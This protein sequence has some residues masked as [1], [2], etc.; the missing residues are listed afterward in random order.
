MANA[1]ISTIPT[2]VIIA[3]E[4]SVKEREYWLEKLSGSP[5]KATFPYDYNKKEPDQ[6]K[7]GESRSGT[8]ETVKFKLN[9][10]VFSKLI[11]IINES[12][13]RLHMLMVAAAAVLL[14][15]YN[16]TNG[17]ERSIIVGSPIYKQDV[18]GDFINLVLPLKNRLENRMTFKEVLFQA[19]QAIEEAVENQNY[20]METLLYDLK[21]PYND[22]KD[23][24]P[25]FDTAILVQNIHDRNYIRHIRVNTIFSFLRTDE[26]IEGTVEYNPAYFKKATIQRIVSHF[27]NLLEETLFNVDREIA[28]LDLLADEE[29]N[30]ILIQFNAT[31]AAYPANKAIPQLFEQQVEGVPHSVAVICGNKYITYNELNQ[32]ANRLAR[33]LSLRGAKP[34]TI[35]GI[36]LERSI[37][38]IV[39]ILGI[40]KTGSAYMPQDPN[41]PQERLDYM[42]KDS[43]ASLVVTEP[44]SVNRFSQYN[45]SVVCFTRD[46]E[47]MMKQSPGNFSPQIRPNGL[48]YIIYTSG[49]TG[50]PKGVLIE[51]QSVANLKTWYH[52]T[53]GLNSHTRVLQFFT[54]SFDGAVGETFTSLLNGAV[55]V[56]V[57]LEENPVES[58]NRYKINL[59]VFVPSVLRQLDPKWL[60]VP[61]KLFV[62]SAGEACTPE[63]F[64]QWQQKCVFLNGYGPTETTVTSHIRVTTRD[65]IE[66][67][68]T[69]PIGKP[70]SNFKSYILDSHLN[71]VPLGVDGEIYIAGP[72]VARGYLN[73]VSM[74]CQRFITDRVFPDAWGNGKKPVKKM[75]KTGDIGR[76]FP[77]GNV[78]FFGRIDQQVKIRGYRIEPGE[79][80]TRLL[81]LETVKEAVV[82][83]MEGERGEK[84]LYA[85]IVSDS[86]VDTAELRRHLSNHL[87][88]FMIPDHMIQVEKIPL[89]PSG[90][91]DRKALQE[92]GLV[93]DTKA[94]VPPRNYLER[95]LQAI[96]SQVLGIEREK[97]SINSNF[98]ELG[99]H[100]LK[101][102]VLISRI[103]KELNVKIPMTEFFVY[104]TISALSGY[105]KEAARDRYSSIEPVEEKEYYVLSSAQKRLYIL[106]QMDLDSTAYNI[107][108]RIPLAGNLY[109]EKLQEAFSKLIERHASLRT[110]FHLVNDCPVQRVHREVEF[111]IEYA[112]LTAKTRPFDLAQAPILQ[113]RLIN[114]GKNSH[115]LMIDMHHIVSDGISHQVLVQDFMALYKGEALPWLRLQYKDFSQWQ[116]NESQKAVIKQQ[117]VYWLR[118]FSGEIPVLNLPTD[119]KRPVIQRFEGSKVRFGISADDT[120]A[121]KTIASGSGATVFMVLLSIY[122][123]L[124]LKLSNQ[125]DIIIGTPVAGRRHADLEKIIGMF[126]NTLALR[127]FPFGEKT[128][129][130]FLEEVKERALEAFDN[131]EYQ[132]EDLVEQVEVDRDPGR[133]PLFDVMF[134]MQNIKMEPGEN[135]ETK[136]LDE[137]IP[138]LELEEE[139]TTTSKFDMTLNAVESGKNLLF[140][141]TCNTTLFDK[142]TIR[143]FAVYFKRIISSIAAAS[144][145]KLYQLEIISAEEKQQLLE[146]FNQTA[147]MKPPDKTIHQLFSE[148]S[149]KSP[150]RLA[151]V[152]NQGTNGK[153]GDTRTLTSRSGLMSITYKEL[154]QESRQLAARL[155]GKGI[156][157]GSIAAIMLEPSLEIIAAIMAVIKTGA[158]YLPIDPENPWAR[159]SYMLEDSAAKLLLT[160]NLPRDWQAFT[161][162]T[163]ELRD[164]L[165]NDSKVEVPAPTAAESDGVYTIYTSGTTGKP[166]GVI[167]THENLVNYVNWFSRETGLNGEDSTIL[168][169]SFAFDLGYTCLYPCLLKGGQLHILPKETYMFPASLSDYMGL[170]G[171]SYLKMTPSLF[172]VLVDDPNF[173]PETCWGLRLVVLGGEAINTADVGTAFGKFNHIRIM[174]HYGPTES[175]IGC[176]AQFVDANHLDAYKARPTIGKPIS[177]LNV[178]ILDK[179]WQL[180]PVGAAGELVLSGTGLAKGYLNRPEL[181]AKGFCL[182]RTR[183]SGTLRWSFHM[184]YMSH[185][186]YIFYKTHDLARWL[187]NGIIEFLGRIDQQ[188]KLRGYR[189]ELG[190]IQNRL[191]A[192]KEIKEAVV[193][194]S[195]NDTGNQYLCAYVVPYLPGSSGS[196]TPLELKEY[197]SQSLP[198]YMIPG[199][200][201]RLERIPLTTNGKL[202]RKA[203]PQPE[204]IA[205]PEDTGPRDHIEEKLAAIWSELLEIDKDKL[206]MNSNFFELGGH[207][208]KAVIM[209]SKVHQALNV[210][211]PLAEFFKSPSLKGISAY[212]RN[213]VPEIFVSI[214]PAEKKEY[215]SLSSAQLRIY[216]LQQMDIKGVVYNMPQFIPLEKE[217][218]RQQMETTFRKLIERHESLRTS[219][220]I[221]GDEPVQIIHPPEAVEFGIEYDDLGAESS[222]IPAGLLPGNQVL[223]SGSQGLSLKVEKIIG[224][225]VRPFGLGRPPLLRVKVIKMV[226]GRCMLMTD[227][228]HVISDGVSRHL[229]QEDFITLEQGGDLPG[230][231]IQYK[232]YSEWQKSFKEKEKLNSQEVYW[233]KEFAGEIPLLNL[234][235]DYPRPAVQSFEGTR[236]NFEIGPRVTALMREYTLEQ[237]ATMYM[238]LI[239]ITFIFLS[240]LSGQEEIVLGVPVAG[241]RHAELEKI[242]GMFVN[243]LALKNTVNS[244]LTFTAFMQD[245]KKRSVQALDNQEY[246]FE[247]LVD[248]VN[249][250]RDISR[251]ALFDVMFALRNLDINQQTDSPP[252]NEEPD[253]SQTNNEYQNIMGTSKFDL[254]LDVTAGQ[255]LLISIEYSTKLF[256]RET[257]QRFSR[258]F[259]QVA[260]A[261]VY[262]PS[263]ILGEI[264]IISA[265]EKNE[266]LMNFNNTTCPYP[267]EKTVYQL[268]QA[269]IGR[270]PREIAVVY[271]DGQLTYSHL[272]HTA[273]QWG[274]LLRKKGV[275][276]GTIAAIMVERSLEMIISV[277]AVQ[278]AGGAYLPLDPS[279]PQPRIAYML[280]DSD[281]HLLL[282]QNHIIQQK[283]PGP[284]QG[285]IPG[286]AG[287][288]IDI[289]NDTRLM[290]EDNS[291]WAP[292]NK[293]GDLAYVIYTSGSTGRSKGV[294]VQNN[295]YVNA[296]F[297]W[298]KEYRLMEMEV[299]LLQIASFSFDVFAGDLAR[300]LFHGGKLVICPEEVRPDLDALVQLI[301]KHRVSIF[302][303]TPSLIIP[304]MEYVY[305]N[306]WEINHLHLLI[307]GSDSFSVEDYRKLVTRFG[308]SM[309]IINSY[310]VTEATIDTSFYEGNLENI[311][312]SGNVPIGIPLANMKFYIMDHNA[313]LLPVGITGE[314]FI[315]GESVARG[316]LNR[317]QLTRERFLSHPHVPG[318][319]IYKTGDL[320]RWLS[321]G[322][323]DFLGRV[324]QQVKIRG[325]RIELGEIEAYLLTYK[326]VKD[327]VVAA[328]A[329]NQDLCAYIVASEALAIK[330]IREYLSGNL[331]GYMIPSYFMSIEKIPLTPGGKVDRKALPSPEIKAA[332]EYVAPRTAVEETLVHLWSKV[333]K[334]N[335]AP[336]E[337]S[338]I[339]IDDNFFEL[340]G[341]SLKATILVSRIHKALD[342]QLPLVE[343]FKTPSV[344]GLAQSIDRA[345]TARYAAIETV[346]KK[347][348]YVLSSAQK[349]L[350][351][352]QHL[353]PAGTAYNTLSITPLPGEPNREKLASTFKQLINRH[354]SLRTSY[355]MVKEQPVQKVH[356][357][358]TAALNIEYYDLEPGN[359]GEEQF[360]AAGVIK[361][362][363]K[364]FDLSQVPLMHVGLVRIEKTKHLLVVEKH[365]IITDGFSDDI[366]AKDF[367][368]LYN[369]EELPCLR[370]QY[371]DFSR[372]QN[373]EK[374]KKNIKKQES[375]WLKEFEGEIPVLSIP[376]DYPRPSLQSFAGDMIRVEMPE[377]HIDRL[378]Q[379]ALE[380]GAT[381]FMVL[382]ALCNIF[383]YKLS[384]QEDVVVGT[385]VVGRR[386]ADLEKIIGMFVNTLP[387]RNY[388][389]GERSFKVFLKEVKNR[390]LEAFENQEYQFED[391]VDRVSVQ[392]DT[393]RNPLFDFMFT[394]QT[395]GPGPGNV[396]P[397]KGSG[398][399]RPAPNTP[400]Q[401]NEKIFMT[402][403]FD[404]SISAMES[405]KR[406][407]LVFQYCT[408]LYKK[409]TIERFMVF[410][411]RIVSAITGEVE[412]KPEEIEIISE[413]EKQQV[414]I[415]FNQTVT[416]Y[417]KDKTIHELFQEQSRKSPHRT[418]VLG[419]G[420]AALGTQYLSYQELDKISNQLA[421]L[422]REKGVKTDMIVG[423]MLEHS[424]QMIIVILGILKAGAAYLPIDPGYPG[425]RIDFMMN[426]SS[427]RVLLVGPGIKV[428]S[429]VEEGFIETIDI[430]NLL[431]SSNLVSA[432]VST[433]QDSP[434]NLAYVLYTSGTTGRPKGVMVSH[435]AVVNRLYW[436]KRKYR[437]DESDVILQKTPFTFDVSVCELFRWIPAGARLCFLAR[438]GEM[439]P[440]IMIETIE[441]HRV[442]T[443]DFVPSLL[444]AFLGYL[445]EPAMGKRLNSLRWVFIGAEVVSLELAAAFREK[446]GSQGNARLINAYGPTE[447]TVDVTYFD[448]SI[449]EQLSIIPIGKPMDNVQ[450]YILDRG[451][452]LQ[453]I[454]VP[455][456][457]CIGGDCLARGYLNRPELTDDKFEIKNS[458]LTRTNKK[459]LR[460][461]P[462]GAVFSKS[463]PLAA[464]GQVYHT[465]DLACWQLDG[466]I[467][468][469]GRIDQQV[470]I[471]GFRV[472]LAEIENRLLKH[473]QVKDA[474]VLVKE[475][476]SADKYLYAYIVS[477]GEF[478]VL[479]LKE[480]LYG[481]L[482]AYMIPAYFMQIERIPLTSSGKVNKPA[483]PA[484]EFIR[485]NDYVA[486]ASGKEIMIADVWK[487]ELKLEQVGIH[488]NFFEMGGNSIKIIQVSS[489]L[490]QLSGREIP[491]ARLFQYPTIAALAR[492]LEELEAGQESEAPVKVNVDDMK[493]R[494]AQR[495]KRVHI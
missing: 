442:T 43:A 206:G 349:R 76:Y 88:D 171:I 273:K 493:D 395:L 245:V 61:G 477:T 303:S 435:G 239:A 210:K 197:L 489:K 313:R 114:P 192:H 276:P 59:A 333:L 431:S 106:Q 400:Q 332:G 17:Q 388:P 448:C 482:P 244:E 102:T 150:D 271:E 302:E 135:G 118:E 213:A 227:V 346:E 483:L 324:D 311:P 137:K 181:T 429:D 218:T 265:A 252:A 78:G 119:F 234:P 205:S 411:Q 419:P 196:L 290:S 48:A 376:T 121:L 222:D 377:E 186:P 75:Y 434:A 391:L 469:L 422:L 167:V 189:I 450:L 472:E 131:Q 80:E 394:L 398:E 318:E 198:D 282:T 82:I 464:G 403:Q 142:T 164:E 134:S 110:S 65:D 315:G 296:A 480:Y 155:I 417:P 342:V 56:M 328:V 280:E 187:A 5:G 427:A 4:Q 145:Q 217:P 490:K 107:P 433:C 126:V 37:E 421:Y 305:E 162:E 141:L 381:L 215:Y 292:V 317:V 93:A 236:F 460:G 74:T 46:R 325:Y 380:E 355:H 204:I 97:I 226:K 256:K 387:L 238:V 262:N 364:P 185:M 368:A 363:I 55:L 410:F 369:G 84:F 374:E 331:P 123:I 283:F 36:M 413:E 258:F 30:Q 278:E 125:E 42:I 366:L 159:I 72:G 77:D 113:V 446:I 89:T 63:L 365:H 183:C 9:S 412:V 33:V 353:E 94:Y 100:S 370:I 25:L 174:N 358:D 45:L 263:I 163:L 70:I 257:I 144:H 309:R 112:D 351:V 443:S 146:G 385:P 194:A 184:S 267:G 199:Y 275:K 157:P 401:G 451:N 297:A 344:R 6:H 300:A 488:D 229:L 487:E 53:F 16:F 414:L 232:D 316:Y 294:M 67:Y 432:P 270:V 406:L 86:Q 49:S 360:Q 96:W 99:G 62:I 124:L 172:G 457:L 108:E 200:F 246:P 161:T 475:D 339:G 330:E 83:P 193:L 228:H 372:W 175:T 166:K 34:E 212:V 14:Y 462:G 389:T 408:K 242:I 237:G 444:K 22:S 129:S 168:T 225:F 390:A 458:E 264:D 371:K 231:L 352:L 306:Q 202:D 7:S 338:P 492:Y 51:H 452:H 54:Y 182:R 486:P 101:A 348:Y 21:I 240:K 149:E 291:D 471:R 293:P 418:A 319:R 132:F 287:E 64:Q 92:L 340:G 307:L 430:S 153:P 23:D 343:I 334:G 243:T 27:S 382:L 367:L 105:I 436:V 91:V 359:S 87:P 211:I 308:K 203:L 281:A 220:A 474:V 354:E 484:I 158:C 259:Q 407:F 250:T 128:F 111:E 476:R 268:F 208:L 31:D 148:Q 470:K 449:D 169:S 481:Y 416:Q 251:N 314:L 327:A 66:E 73:R 178:F 254:S 39:G 115:I 11:W 140:Y 214:N 473:P 173:S 439:E 201:I 397:G 154:N 209:I 41:F 326:G 147:V 180:Q 138:T 241:R 279:L 207:S 304:L 277:M 485:E 249:A 223:P 58:L 356:D 299:N 12:D 57:S 127:N 337:S 50:L 47:M 221:V 261:V 466:N 179:Y 323:I 260:A 156:G 170:R 455:G 176:I 2:E 375:Y 420:A 393:S 288:T 336:G 426:D 248:K 274:R 392:R 491:V 133:N 456:E 98:F 272:D 350:Y 224:D 361:K 8:I 329:G 109:I 235:T 38:L 188:V 1:S 28:T 459:F 453:P 378:K 40:L 440:A 405:G 152:G 425:G 29:K 310:G 402:S 15:K 103:H 322:I 35:V 68:P 177:N 81:V 438:G 24:F 404:L 18:E 255:N 85:Y 357:R 437:L 321:D 26:Y 195:T 386:H 341:N 3:A 447:A 71:P 320:A 467:C 136:R 463:A 399:K 190:E 478:E 461:G 253:T 117:E 10:K 345:A 191:L 379:M 409:E 143:R 286:F 396:T 122:N 285:E 347:E 20:P 454:G 383:L 335:D 295:H 216:I 151:L 116:N 445:E 104:P 219:F 52:D 495:R 233:L 32:R 423:L 79:V 266:I 160:K 468:F 298:R 479:E 90:K 60:Q 284:N 247:D 312:Q 69:I 139:Q 424:V 95:K 494:L 301:R 373:S 289:E 230:L 415:E 130:Q 362:L 465:G 441:K 44:G 428:K 120:K 19:K 269:Q 13:A 384:S 165:R